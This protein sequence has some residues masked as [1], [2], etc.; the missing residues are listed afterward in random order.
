M[1]TIQNLK[2]GKFSNLKPK[3]DQYLFF[4]RSHPFCNNLL[5]YFIQHYQIP[6]MMM[7]IAMHPI[8][9]VILI[10]LVNAERS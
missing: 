6:K 5:D 2:S 8:P 1:W 4:Y 10:M 7:Q 9:I 3:T